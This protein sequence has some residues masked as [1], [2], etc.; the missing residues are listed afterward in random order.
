MDDTQILALLL[1]RDEQGLKE[2]ELKYGKRLMRLARGILP[3]E[4]ALECVNDSYLAVWNSIP[5]NQPEYLFAYAAKICRNLALNRVE[6]EGAT[7]RNAVVVE[8]SEELSQ[9]IPDNSVTVEQT[10][11]AQLIAAF[12]KTLPAEKRSLFIRRYWY[13]ESVRELATSFGWREGKVKSI[14]F[15]LRNQLWNELNK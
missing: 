7:K 1:A 6:W 15:R 14:L 8:L 5:P 9:C 2:L 3:E 11:L 13:G 12:L 4:D 10:E